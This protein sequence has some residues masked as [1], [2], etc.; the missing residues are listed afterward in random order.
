MA[1][2]GGYVVLGLGAFGKSVALALAEA[3]QEV[4]VVDSS[5]SVIDDIKSF[6]SV[7]IIGD[8]TKRDL[9]REIQISE[10]S[11]AIVCV[12]ELLE[13]SILAT[14]ACKELGCP[15]VIAKA[16]SED[17]QQIL[18]RVGADQV[19]LPEQN[20]ARQLAQALVNPGVLDR[21]VL[22]TGFSI[23][24]TS[25]PPSWVGKNL[26]QLGIRRVYRL[27]VIAIERD[28]GDG[29]GRKATEVIANPEPD[30]EFC[31]GDVLVL[32]GNDRALQEFQGVE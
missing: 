6:V 19:V 5:E 25:V 21:Y 20:M 4:T 11:A 12:G 22:G 31:A 7:S 16:T 8:V 30:T 26:A 10:A 14:L 27:S 32:L 15:R 1:K 29:A 28:P 13:A 9:L 24:K 18:E 23:I 2:N 17:H 3:N